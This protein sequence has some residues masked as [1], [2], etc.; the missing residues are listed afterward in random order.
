MKGSHL[1]KFAMDSW[2]LL[3]RQRPVTSWT[4]K[5]TDPHEQHLQTDPSRDGILKGTFVT[6]LPTQL[7]TVGNKSNKEKNLN[8]QA[9]T[10]LLACTKGTEIIIRRSYDNDIWMTK[11]TKTA[12]ERAGALNGPEPPSATKQHESKH[13]IR[14]QQTEQTLKSAALCR[15]STMLKQQRRWI[16]KR[17]KKKKTLIIHQICIMT[18]WAAYANAQCAKKHPRHFGVFCAR[19]TAVEQTTESLEEEVLCRKKTFGFS[20]INLQQA[21]L[22]VRFWHIFTFFFFPPT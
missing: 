22:R 7:Q 18:T 4:A 19:I 21:P 8:S 1:G 20:S 6:R 9:A 10:A 5:T 11:W 16:H 14:R 15:V 2:R 3:K 17:K 12:R 13:S